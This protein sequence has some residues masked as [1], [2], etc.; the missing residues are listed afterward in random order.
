MGKG[1]LILEHWVL[2]ENV[3][4]VGDFPLANWVLVV[5]WEEVEEIEP[6]EVSLESHNV[7]DALII[8]R[9]EEY[10]AMV[11]VKDIKFHWALN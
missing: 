5:R 2:V 3:I 7:L 9:S 11:L 8:F 10:R 6:S 4:E 1:S